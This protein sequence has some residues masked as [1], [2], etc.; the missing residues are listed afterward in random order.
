[1]DHKNGQT[2]FDDSLSNRFSIFIVGLVVSILT[3]S[4]GWVIAT[5]PLVEQGV[6]NIW[7]RLI[8]DELF[9][10]M[11]LLAIMAMV[12]AVA[13]PRFAENYLRKTGRRF[14]LLV[15]VGFI[16]F[17]LMGMLQAWFFK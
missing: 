4:L 16:A 5:N 3:G 17:T 7:V 6:P 15:L 12:W 8:F 2:I 10:T 9:L 11:F 1:M 14:M 13:A